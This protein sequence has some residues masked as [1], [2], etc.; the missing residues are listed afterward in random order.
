MGF[1][2]FPPAVRETGPLEVETPHDYLP[3]RRRSTVFHSRRME[4]LFSRS[5]AIA[6][7]L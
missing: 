6:R 3:S 4:T 5:E 7:A 2:G 1:N